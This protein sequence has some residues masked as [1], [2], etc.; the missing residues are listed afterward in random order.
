MY[1]K[2]K[3]PRRISGCKTWTSKIMEKC[4]NKEIRGSYSSFYVDVGMK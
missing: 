4:L 2:T 1:L 3:M